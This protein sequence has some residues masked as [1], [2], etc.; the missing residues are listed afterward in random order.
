VWAGI[1]PAIGPQHYSVGTE[2]V[3]AIQATLPPDAQVAT[4]REGRWAMDLPAALEAQL[5]AVGVTQI[6][7]SGLCTA[8]RV[9]EWY[10][11]RAEE[12]R[13]GRFGVLV[14]L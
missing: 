4:Y 5:H 14:M 2:V 3:E 8:S 12:G 11:H 7:Q 10:S 6:E 13:T 9:D 1:G